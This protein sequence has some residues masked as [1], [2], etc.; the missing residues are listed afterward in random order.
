MSRVFITGASTGLGHGLA[1]HYAK[2]G[3][4]LGLL[5]RRRELLD[6]LKGECEQRGA[7]AHVYAQDVADTAGM[8]R[9]IE[10]FLAAAGGADLVIANAG[11]GVKSGLLEGR[12]DDVA[13]LLGINVIGVTNTIVPFVPAMV[14]QGSGTLVAVGSVAGHRAIPGRAAYSAS[15]ACVKTFMDGL[16]MDLNGTGVHAMTLMPGFVDTPLTVDNPQMMFVLDADTAVGKMVRAIA[17]ERSTFTFPWQMNVLSRLM[18][19]APEALL[20]RAAPKPRTRSST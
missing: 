6:E 3:A 19:I 18:K 9:A 15:K 14:Q 11:V 2:P 1:L 17:A 13:W 5:A 8:G 20:R 4:V 7:T 12:A 10:S 16:R